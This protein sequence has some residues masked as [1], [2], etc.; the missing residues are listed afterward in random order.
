MILSDLIAVAKGEKE[1]DLLL[2]KARIVN[3]FT[4]EIEKGNVAIAQGYVAGIGDYASGKEVIDLGGRYLAPGLIDGH[5]HIESSFL[6]PAEYARAVVPRGTLA[7]I[8]DLHEIANVTGLEGL[9]YMIQATRRLPLDFFFMAPSCV[10]ATSL[11]TAG[12]SLSP[13]EVRRALRLPQVLG[14][15]EMMNFPG[16]LGANPEVLQK[17]QAAGG[18]VMDGHAPSLRGQAL[19]AYIAAGIQSDHESTELEEGREKLRRGL[20]LMIREGSSEKNLETLLPLVTDQT[21]SRCLLVVDDRSAADILKDGD[22]DAVVR[23]AVRLGLDPG[24]ALQLA[25][26]NPARYFGLRGLGAIAPGYLANL[27]V[28]DD[29]KRLKVEQ[30]FY[31][32]RLVAQ[33]GQ[34]LFAPRLQKSEAMPHTVRVKPFSKA[35][36]AL[37]HHPGPFPVIQVIPGQ[38]LTKRVDV[39]PATQDGYIVADVERDLLKLVVVE[40]HRATGNLGRGLVRG[41]GLKRGA[42]ASSLAHDSHNIVAVGVSDDDLYQAIQEV[43]RLQGGLVAVAGG[44]VLAS[45]ALPVAGLLSMKPLPQV[46]AKLEKLE[47][48]ASQLGST[49]PAPFAA[50]SFVALPVI[51][52]L[53]LTD[54]GLVDVLAG[55]FLR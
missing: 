40:R 42:L 17:I 51:P 9:R 14:L 38:I 16:V 11:E 29:L 53:R 37:P 28:F 1:P 5:V 13:Q 43:I 44:K 35:V 30:V 55:K 34:A 45:L 10:P 12:A 2:R 50:L 33:E 26:I 46:V 31:R 6:H 39:E 8:T 18:K 21:Y 23:K 41:F 27:I 25:T 4:A 3:T 20:H 19:N 47:S 48:A 32:G 54:R 24:R 22:L 7:L 49:L 15:G 52:E 36:L